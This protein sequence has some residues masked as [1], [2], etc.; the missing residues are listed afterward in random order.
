[1]KNIRFRSSVAVVEKLACI[2]RQ[3][4]FFAHKPVK[5]G[6]E[7]LRT[8]VVNHT[9]TLVKPGVEISH[10]SVKTVFSQIG[11]IISEEIKTSGIDV[12]VYRTVVPGIIALCKAQIQPYAVALPFVFV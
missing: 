12:R 7:T 8:I 11:V 2:N 6:F 5:A 1:M 3:R 4:G 9:E 10:I